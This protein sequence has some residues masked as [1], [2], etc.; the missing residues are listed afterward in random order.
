MSAHAHVLHTAETGA[1]IIDLE[2]ASNR[3]GMYEAVAPYRQLYVFQII[4][5]WTDLRS[6]LAHLAYGLGKEEIPFFG[7]IFGAFYNED[8]YLRTRKTW[9]SL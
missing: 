5:Y 3:T 7:E 4:R 1:E 6:E 9:I 8:S 2:E